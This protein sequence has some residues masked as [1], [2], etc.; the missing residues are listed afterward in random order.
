LES[1]ISLKA[2]GV[3][4]KVLATPRRLSDVAKH[5]KRLNFIVARVSWRI[6]VGL[7]LGWT[8]M[9]Q[10]RPQGLLAWG[11]EPL[12]SESLDPPRSLALGA[13][14]SCRLNIRAS[15]LC[16]VFARI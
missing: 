11:I 16:K 5:R 6:G 4:L 8:K 1:K 12:L 2:D 9:D 14:H 15:E 7:G 3:Q 13:T 10:K